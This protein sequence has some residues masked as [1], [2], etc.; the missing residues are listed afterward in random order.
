MY[1]QPQRTVQATAC[2]HCS[3]P[4]FWAA[5][6]DLLVAASKPPPRPTRSLQSRQVP[7]AL[8]CCRGES[9]LVNDSESFPDTYNTH[10]DVKEQFTDAFSESR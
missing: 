4:A 5:E 7:G 6:F 2:C 3:L 10:K 8:A 9:S 1:D